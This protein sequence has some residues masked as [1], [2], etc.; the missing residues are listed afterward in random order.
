ME[1]TAS[2][3]M[4]LDSPVSTRISKTK[5]PAS[6]LWSTCMVNSLCLTWVE[7]NL[8]MLRS[9]APLV[10][11]ALNVL[12]LWACC[13]V[14]TCTRSAGFLVSQNLEMSKPHRAPVCTACEGF[15]LP[16]N[17]DAGCS[18]YPS[19]FW[20]NYYSCSGTCYISGKILMLVLH[21]V[22]SF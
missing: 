10:W 13:T 8:C 11:Q 2:I 19:S 9:S 16:Q 18:V 21:T 5:L 3:L 20:C 6:V 15:S 17:T 4:H 12:Q 7:D 22:K 1:S 14:C